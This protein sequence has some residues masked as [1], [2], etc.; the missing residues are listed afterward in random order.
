V[1]D[2]KLPDP[3]AKGGADSPKPY[4][5]P[6][7]EMRASDADRERVADV[8]REAFA[9]GRLDAEEHAERLEA[10][11]AAKTMGDL[12]PLTKDLPDAQAP[13][14]APAPSETYSAPAVS[15]KLVAIFGGAERKGRFRT[16]R[17]F[18]AVAIFGGV[19]I[20]LRDATFDQH[21][22]VINCTAIFG[23][24]DIKVPEHVTL[25]GGGAGIFGGFDVRQEE[26]SQPHGPVVV[27]RGAAVFGGVSARH[28][29][30]SKLKA[31]L[32]KALEE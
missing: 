26:G 22:I 16:G 5:D 18:T 21:E 30:P 29:R 27:V 17:G 6:A 24:V 15:D 2:A 25:R 13:G 28:R 12:V 14:A 31:K 8:L 19:D 20:D 1:D 11:Y 9:E 3:L 4:A 32:R 10:V 23:G 7:L